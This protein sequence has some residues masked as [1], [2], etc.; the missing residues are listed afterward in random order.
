M[1]VD[2]NSYLYH[3]YAVEYKD[4]EEYY[5]ELECADLVHCLNCYI[6]EDEA[7]WVIGDVITSVEEG[8]LIA[9]Q[10]LG[11]NHW[12]KAELMKRIGAIM[13]LPPEEPQ[14]YVGLRVS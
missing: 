2:F 14:I 7:N 8:E 5:D 9:V 4:I 10:D 12:D 1:S 6:E 13:P 11:S 3:G